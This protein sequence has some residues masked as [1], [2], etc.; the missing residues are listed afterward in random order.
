MFGF[1]K[2]VLPLVATFVSAL[3]ITACSIKEE[4][5][6]CPC[7]LNLNY[8]SIIHTFDYKTA[9]VTVIGNEVVCQENVEIIPLEGVGNEY[10]VPRRLNIATCAVGHENLWWHQDT[11]S[12]PTGLDWG[13]V[14]V[15]SQEV[16]CTSDLAHV[17][18]N[19]HKEYCQINFILVGLNDASK[20]PFDIRVRANCNALRM[21]DR[22]PISG[23]YTSYAQPENTAELF[24]VHVPRQEN[25]EMTVDLLYKKADHKYEKNDLVKTYDI[26]E[27][28]DSVGYNWDKEDLDDLYITIDFV[29]GTF[30]VRI[31]PWIEE[32][33]DI[34]I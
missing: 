9:L 17:D 4:R 34:R 19:V 3:V 21:R 22:K 20:Y 25:N 11:L 28:L 31:L 23:K 32:G 1:K 24:R 27:A 26:G 13:K 6:D 33:L 7:W 30:S 18:F 10:Q 2:H 12:V 16:D 29:L 14:Y 5:M 15:D 8:D